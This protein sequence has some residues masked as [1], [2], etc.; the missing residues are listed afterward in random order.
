MFLYNVKVAFRNISKRKLY[1]VINIV[2]LAIGLASFIVISLYIFDELSYDRYHTKADR[3]YRV[4]NVY[5]FKGVGEESSSCPYPVA[6]HLLMDYPGYI[7][8]A[9]RLFNNWST[10]YFVEYGN[11]SF[12]E[13]HLFFVDSTFFDVFD[14]HFTR[15]NPEKALNRSST[16]VITESAAKRYFGDEDPIGRSIRVEENINV[17]VT[18]IIEDTPQQSH[19]TYDI[20]ISMST[21]KKLF[22]GGE[23]KTWVW[24]PFWT[25]IVL[26]EDVTPDEV[27]KL[28]PGFI[29]KY[30][31]DAEKTNLSLYLQPLEDIHLRSSLDYEIQPNGK[32][33]YIRI[34]S[35]IG[36]FLLIIAS[37]NFMNLATAIAGRRAREIGMKK[38][39]GA[40][41]HQLV[42]QF[43][44]ESV[45]LSII[46]LLIALALVEIIIPYFNDFTGKHITS[47]YFLEPAKLVILLTVA[48][49]TGLISGIYPA[50]YLSSFRPIVVLRGELDHGLKGVRARKILVVAQFVISIALIIITIISFQQ[51]RFFQNKDLG[52]TTDNIVYLPVIQTPLAYKYDSFKQELLRSPDIKSVTSTDYVVGVE[53]NTHEFRPEGF[54]SDQWQFYPALVVQDDFIETFDIEVVAGRGFYSDS[55]MDR[56]HAVLIN[57]A[58]VKHLNWGSNQEALGKSF[59]SNLGRE[60]VIG[61]VKDFHVNSLHSEVTPMA[62]F[63][64]ENDEAA[65]Y[66]TNYI[67]I[68]HMPG[69]LKNVIEYAGD[70][71]DKMSPERPFEYLIHKEEI[72]ELYEEE[73]ILGRLSAVLTILIVLI[74]SLGL[75]GLASYMVDQRTKE[76]SIRR[77]VG[78]GM[79]DIAILLSKEFNWMLLIAN[80]IAWPVSF[81]LMHYWLQNFAYRISINV[82]VFIVAAFLAFIIAMGITMMKTISLFQ[83]KAVDSIKY[84]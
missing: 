66:F 28:F 32:I 48:L 4:I 74:A 22:G 78:A 33:V 54:P 9:V 50:F 56:G 79:F 10:P 29:Q 82:T 69:A 38:V 55:K 51:I 25:Y 59:R 45:V 18:G 62:V 40:Y 44:T 77:V 17:V 19:F 42:S 27:E 35:L 39:V 63:M 80:I 26:K 31:Y 24:N 76:L 64:M 75:Y 61:V 20:L 67:A 60:K 49:I 21:I 37:I 11:K 58:M 30:F 7:E 34:L 23:P 5:D 83:T 53:H 3:I 52:F 15:G 2:G 13:K 14:V 41:R 47:N 1:S 12:R 43:I 46:G 72:E 68:R 36:L 6:P 65:V 70:I 81:L 73:I 16:A 84:E 71:W 57:E 8:N